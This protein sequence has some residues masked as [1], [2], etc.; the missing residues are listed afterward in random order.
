MYSI[1]W[2]ILAAQNVC[3]NQPESTAPKAES[4]PYKLP[5]TVWY[6]I[7]KLHQVECSDGSKNCFIPIT[8]ILTIPGCKEDDQECKK[9]RRELI[10]ALEFFKKRA[11]E[12]AAQES[13]DDDDTE[14]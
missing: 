3:G 2:C 13:D 7:Q 11:A 10:A 5:I 4:E 12:E 14:D 6:P 1:A 9:H 8:N